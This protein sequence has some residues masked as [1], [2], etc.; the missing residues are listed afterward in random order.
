[1]HDYSID[2]NERLLIPFYLAIL[3]ILVMGGV[4]TLL[5]CIQFSLPWW[6][7][8]ISVFGFYGLFLLIFDRF[9]WK[10]KFLRTLNIIKTPNLSGKYEG[11]LLSSYSDFKTPIPLNVEVLQTWTKINIIWRTATS[12]SKSLVASIIVQNEPPVLTYQFLNQ[13]F[14]TTPETMHEHRGTTTAEIGKDE[15]LE[16]GCYSNRDRKTSG[17]F[18][19]KKIG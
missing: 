13:P 5:N 8:G 14:Q 10:W 11:T 12:S 1:M 16:G 2:S 9:V 15:T 7:D 3:S 18:S 6:V 17:Q 19:L 4:Q